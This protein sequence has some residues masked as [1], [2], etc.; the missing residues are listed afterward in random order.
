MDRFY[1]LSRGM[2]MPF[3]QVGQK[4]LFQFSPS[5]LSCARSALPWQNIRRTL[6]L[7][8]WQQSNCYDESVCFERVNSAEEHAVD[9]FNSFLYSQT[10]E[11]RMALR[12]QNHVLM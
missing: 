11:S 6:F 3:I 4:N 8:S 2:S 1:S 12:V 5:M 10:F 9:D 7:S